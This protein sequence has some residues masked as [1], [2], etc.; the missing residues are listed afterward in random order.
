MS[1]SMGDSSDAPNSA[2]PSSGKEL[3]KGRFIIRELPEGTT[4]VRGGGVLWSL[5]AKPPAL[6]YISK[7]S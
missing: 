2:K 7:Y 6:V 4:D 1:V 5:C 3:K